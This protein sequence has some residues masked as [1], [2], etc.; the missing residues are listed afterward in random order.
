MTDIAAIIKGID[1]LKPI[2]QVTHK[3]MAI[4]GNTVSSAADL[5]DVIQ[6]D[7]ALTANVLKLCNSAF[8]GLA[9]K[10]DS[11]HQAVAYL[12]MDQVVDMVMMNLGSE[13]LKRAQKGYD[14]REG[15]LWKYSVLS[16]FMA[17]DI[18]ESKGLKDKHLVFTSALLKDI[19]KAVLSKHV[20]NYFDEIEKAV[21]DKNITFRD[22]EKL[23]IGI[24]HA[25]LGAIIAE[26]WNF[27]AR[28][29]EIIRNHHLGTGW[30]EDDLELA[31][32]YVADTLC[33]IMGIGVGSDGLA[34][35]FHPKVMKRLQFSDTDIQIMMAS[36][37]ERLHEIEGLLAET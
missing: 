12:G 15:E 20:E 36:F 3:V 9:R 10:I 7:P 13:N 27:S 11:I 30:R 22:A 21:K 35:R 5:A 18:A 33:M 24:D 28:M 1:K 29:V 23:I 34:Y 32:V 17:K 14:L 2:P 26:K 8:F 16:A 4:A 31:A 37:G 19:G 25:E 6:Y